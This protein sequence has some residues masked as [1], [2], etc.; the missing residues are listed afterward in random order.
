MAAGAKGKGHGGG[1]PCHEAHSGRFCS[2][3]GGH[4]GGSVINTRQYGPVSM[5]PATDADRKAA[6]I[7]PGYTNPRVPVHPDA[8]IR[9]QATGPNGKVKTE[10]SAE[11]NGQQAA[12]KFERGRQFNEAVGPA[13]VKWSQEISQGGP[14]AHQA[15]ALRLMHRTGFRNGGD[16]AQTAIRQKGPDG[17]PV[18]V[19]HQ[20]T[21][22]A[23]TL[24]TSHAK[25]DGDRV[26]FDF[27]GKEGV[28]QRHTVQDPLIARHVRT[29]QALGKETLF[30]TT[31]AKNRAYL[32]QTTGGDFKVHDLRTHH[33]TATALVVVKKID[34]RGEAPKTAKELS[35]AQMRVA[36]VVSRRLGNQPEQALKNYIDPTVF[37][38]WQ[39]S[40]SE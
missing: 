5:R 16:D 3:G 24:L 1:N 20:K 30:D 21:Y 11:H 29:R 13:S 23:S 19:G 26:H 37:K 32:K 38:G 36:R 17:K 40:V 35:A 31:D 14:N 25:V 10:Y 27:I 6:K 34:G 33:A 28:R 22:G 18:V 9:W 8:P 15:L 39:T 4:A 2:T 12:A 7:P